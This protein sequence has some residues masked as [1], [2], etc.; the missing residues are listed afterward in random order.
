MDIEQNPEMLTCPVC[1]SLIWAEKLAAEDG[2]CPVCG[3]DT[4]MGGEDESDEEA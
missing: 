3:G 2:F 1:G 4:T